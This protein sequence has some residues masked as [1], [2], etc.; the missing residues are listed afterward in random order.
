MPNAS[1]VSNSDDVNRVRLFVG[2]KRIVGALVM[3]DQ[4][5]SR[6]LHGMIAAQA[7][8]SPIRAALIGE[9]GEGLQRLAAFY[10]EWQGN[11]CLKAASVSDGR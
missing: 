1:F 2:D 9:G 10:Q 5:W 4:T 7:D 11:G 6:P 3:G 8:I